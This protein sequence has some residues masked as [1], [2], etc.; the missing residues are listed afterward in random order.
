M[1]LVEQEVQ[2]TGSEKSL[3]G[4]DVVL[5]SFLGRA[6]KTASLYAVECVVELNDVSRPGRHDAQTAAQCRLFGQ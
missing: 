6:R 4:L 1:R 2:R 3:R 5:L